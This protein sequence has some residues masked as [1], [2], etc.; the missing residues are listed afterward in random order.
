MEKE[1]NLFLDVDL[2]AGPRSEGLAK[3]EGPGEA[4]AF[5]YTLRRRCMRLGMPMFSRSR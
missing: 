4:G 1:A 2:F 5:D 3:Q